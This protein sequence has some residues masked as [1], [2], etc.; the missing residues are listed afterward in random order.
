VISIIT[1]ITDPIRRQDPIYPALKCYD[2]IADEIVVVNGNPENNGGLEYIDDK[3][4]VVDGDWP[5]EFNFEIIGQHFQKGYEAATGDWVI[6][7]DLD[8]FIHEDDIDRLKE[9]LEHEK[10]KPAVCFL[11]MNWVKDDLFLPKARVIFAINK[12]K[13]GD[14]ITWDA[15]T[16]KSKPAY[17]GQEL[18][19]EKL[20]MAIPVINYHFA[21]KEKEQIMEDRY[22]FAKAWEKMTGSKAW[23]PQSPQASY[24]HFLDEIKDRYSK[25][26]NNLKKIEHPKY[27]DMEALPKNRLYHWVDEIY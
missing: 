15:S 22:R 17:D 2:D 23:Q 4:K 26:K 6:K 24:E 20:N 13:C 5:F 1:V 11:K 12:K 10:D 3:V 16:T 21:F 25:H 8:T 9:T 18:R 19:E 14:H 7:L 27:V